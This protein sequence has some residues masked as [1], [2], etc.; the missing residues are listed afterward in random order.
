MDYNFFDA[1]HTDG[2]MLGKQ[3]GDLALESSHAAKSFA[4]SR[5]IVKTDTVVTKEIVYADTVSFS[6]SDSVVVSNDT[7]ETTIIKYQDKYIV[8]TK[9]KP[10]N[11]IRNVEV[12]VPVIE[13]VP[14]PKTRI[15][16]LKD[17]MLLF[18]IA[19]LLSLLIYKLIARWLK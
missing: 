19:L 5:V 17:A 7:V 4:A 10:Y 9:V 13:Y 2:G 11:I 12:K 16:K 1:E 6:G 14:N 3:K 8:K 18:I 15:D